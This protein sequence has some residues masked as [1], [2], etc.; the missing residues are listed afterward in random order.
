MTAATRILRRISPQIRTIRIVSTEGETV[1]LME[2]MTVTR[3]PDG[4]L[5]SF[6]INNRLLDNSADIR[7]GTSYPMDVSVEAKW[8]VT[9]IQAMARTIVRDLILEEER[10]TL[11]AEE[12]ANRNLDTPNWDSRHGV[13]RL[14][15]MVARRLIGYGRTAEQT[16]AMCSVALTRLV[17]PALCKA[18]RDVSGWNARRMGPFMAAWDVVD[19]QGRQVGFSGR[20]IQASC[21]TWMLHGSV[22]QD[23]NG[24]LGI[25][26]LTHGVQYSWDGSG[27]IHV[28]PGNPD[29]PLMTVKRCEDL[30]AICDHLPA[31]LREA[32][33]KPAF[34]R[35][36]LRMR[37]SQIRAMRTLFDGKW[38]QCTTDIMNA[39][40]A[41]GE[42]LLPPKL[43]RELSTR[44]NSMDATTP[45]DVA[46][47]EIL[48]RAA[49]GIS[50]RRS[51][52]T[53]TDAVSEL[54]DVADHIVHLAQATIPKVE[55]VLQD[56][57]TRAYRPLVWNG[58]DDTHAGFDEAPEAE[59]E[60]RLDWVETLKE[61]ERVH[62]LN[63]LRDQ[64]VL[65]TVPGIIPHTRDW[66]HLVAAS[67]AWH[68]ETQQRMDEG[69][70]RSW[71]AILPEPLDLSGVVATELTSAA[72]LRAETRGNDHCVGNG[73]YA[74]MCMAGGTRIFS[75]RVPGRRTRSTVEAALNGA[76]WRIVQHRGPSNS[77]PKPE[78]VAAAK[79][80]MKRVSALQVKLSPANDDRAA[81]IAA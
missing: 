73:E 79:T 3:R 43:I 28:E 47:L 13:D 25:Y 71:D 70:D 77:T 5:V 20:S 56:K 54:F 27:T 9:I 12:E 69:D 52:Q 38:T 18:V 30:T 58:P 16:A 17:D 81:A 53:L 10:E 46:I 7:E 41:I 15:A 57:P 29:S 31:L 74:R 55:I 80:L 6:D 76:S 14:C 2:C 22:Q 49:R 51:R 78:L 40:A 66:K 19:A 1:T 21:L 45:K 48:F 39:L 36:V 75:L 72:D 61:T 42:D 63:R 67:K 64:D 34:W 65:K 35:M 37:V 50:K 26:S 32:G 11:I 68:A 33:V 44:M 4:S 8:I 60:R 59:E 23:E 24:R 62:I